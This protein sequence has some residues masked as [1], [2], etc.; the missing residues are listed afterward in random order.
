MMKLF[1]LPISALVFL[2]LSASTTELRAQPGCV[3]NSL[4]DP[5][6]VCPAIY[7]PVC[8]C[9][10]ITYS[11]DCEAIVHGGVLSWTQG[12]C[13]ANSDCNWLTSS[14]NAFNIPGSFSYAFEDQSQAV[15]GQILSRSWSFGDGASS[16]ELNPDHT[17]STAG[18]YVVC[19]KIQAS[20]SGGH[21][22]EKSFCRLLQVKNDCTD[23]CKYQVQVALKGVELRASLTPALADT[24]FFFYVLWSLDDGAQTGS[25][26]EFN[27]LFSGPGRHTICATYPTGDFTEQT[28]T[29]CKA[30]DVS[31]LCV[32]P[33]QIDSVP[34]PLSYIPVCGC[35]GVT[36]NN[37]CEAVHWGGVTS[38]RLGVCGSI[39]N[40]LLL[41]FDGFNS[42]GS[43]TTWTFSDHSI[44]QGGILT[45]WFWDFGNGQSSNQQNPTVNFQSPGD[46]EV[47]L[48]ASG[49]FADGTQCGGNIC[50]TV[51]IGPQLCVD[52]S[53]I[54]TNV[55]CP[56]I[57]APVCGCNG[58]TYPN[59]CIAYYQNGVTEWTPGP[60]LA[61]CFQPA[62]VD[63]TL[64]CIE[65]YD[66]VCGCDG[67]TYD[68]ACFAQK[69]GITSWTKGPCCHASGC[70]ALFNLEKTG[71]LNV[72]IIN[73]SSNADSV[74]LDMGD[75]HTFINPPDSFLYT[76]AG[77]AIYQ[78]CQHI[79]HEADGC[80]DTYCLLADLSGLSAVQ[81][82]RETW[83]IKISPNPAREQL[84]V[85][86]GQF[87]MARIGLFNTSG[88]LMLTQQPGS[89][90]ALLDVHTL[91]P[92]I[93][94]LQVVTGRGSRTRKIILE[95]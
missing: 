14:F 91:P 28:C 57:Y 67:A 16:T 72:L 85:D 76:Y 59:E 11:N 93:Y 61:D 8:G 55:V 5:N 47:C 22:C 71:G 36:Y 32:N 23:N 69:N 25:G 10:G 84:Q 31:A 92:G 56:A 42:G 26:L 78:I 63:S 41:D 89:S 15:G 49:Q 7:L 75:G 58:I 12:E 51:H 13:G 50:Q 54:D 86:A 20:D 6:A 52:P 62:W 79:Y 68:N 90:R 4:I 21:V 64:P 46:Y 1:P 88:S 77:N 74:A 60:C 30:F 65:I 37:A 3:D 94:F 45:S 81:D 66:P 73:H 29:V 38:W 40:N 35:N 48:Y 24:P 83:E 2:F 33:A 87:T 53:V 44:F 34:C 17:Y 9:D 95:R 82:P 27:T 19:L 39:C 70:Q 43:F 80:T 18:N